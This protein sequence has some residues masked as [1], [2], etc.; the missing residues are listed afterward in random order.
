MHTATQLTMTKKRKIATAIRD[1]L[2]GDGFIHVEELKKIANIIGDGVTPYDCL[3]IAK[4]IQAPTI[5][6]LERPPKPTP[7]ADQKDSASNTP[8][9]I[10]VSETVLRTIENCGIYYKC[11]EDSD[12]IIT[13]K[14]RFMKERKIIR[15]LVQ[16]YLQTQG[17]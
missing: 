11:G 1:R 7:A 4:E 2:D 9:P 8:P 10:D 13:T 6:S 16:H 3:D 5:G 17:Q 12:F 14:D 15:K